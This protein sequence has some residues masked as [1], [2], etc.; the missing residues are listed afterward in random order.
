M[1][2]LRTGRKIS[3][4]IFGCVSSHPRS[5]LLF[6][7]PLS[8][9]PPSHLSRSATSDNI[10]TAFRDFLRVL[11]QE[12]PRESP[13]RSF[14][15][16]ISILPPNSFLQLFQISLEEKNLNSLHLLLS[17]THQSSQAA[18]AIGVQQLA[19]SY[20]PFLHDNLSSAS[21]S[22]ALHFSSWLL[23]MD[24]ASRPKQI[25]T[26]FDT[27]FHQTFHSSLPPFL[28]LY[29][30][31]LKE[32]VVRELCETIESE[33]TGQNILSVLVLTTTQYLSDLNEPESASQLL[34][35][36]VSE[37]WFL[38]TCPLPRPHSLPQ[39]TSHRIAWT[40]TSTEALSSE[41]SRG[42]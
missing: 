25:L 24:K 35:E 11:P 23:L 32:I 1:L 18:A 15:P 42:I 38:F 7:S 9:Y 37:G 26:F 20:S 17:Q 31:I 36:A 39:A 28:A 22:L 14:S 6:V 33:E 16:H 30:E 40:I 2:S 41:L 5:P 12:K 21:K 34:L 29:G 10:K 8:C 27:I 19:H 13:W 4:G 3:G